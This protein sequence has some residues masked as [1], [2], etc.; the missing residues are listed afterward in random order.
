MN[1]INSIITTHFHSTIPARPEF[2]K[3]KMLVLLSV[4]TQRG[5]KCGRWHILVLRK[6]GNELNPRHFGKYR[7]LSIG[8]VVLLNVAERGHVTLTYRT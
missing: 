4:L 6:G 7:V 1:F 8:K 2:V 3:G 5:P